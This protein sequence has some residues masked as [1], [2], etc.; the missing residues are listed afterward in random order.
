MATQKTQKATV[1]HRKLAS[2]VQLGDTADLENQ[3]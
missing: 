1:R 3:V 2:A